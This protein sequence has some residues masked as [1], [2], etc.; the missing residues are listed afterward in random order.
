[1]CAGS[2]WVV[3]VKYIDPVTLALA[4]RYIAKQS[5]NVN[6]IMEYMVSAYGP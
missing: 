2:L 6:I 1:M 5:P 3:C 4:S